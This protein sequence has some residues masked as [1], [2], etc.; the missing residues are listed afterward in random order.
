MASPAPGDRVGSGL[1][2]PVLMRIPTSTSN[3]MA[4]TVSRRRFL[5]HS[6][7]TV[8]GAA[9]LSE[10][11]WVLTAHAVPDDPIR[12]GLIG[13]G[14]R[15]TGAAADALGAATKVI[16]PQAGYHTEELAADAGLASKNVK[17]IALADVFPD[18]LHACRVQ[19]GRLKVIS[20]SELV[21]SCVD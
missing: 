11:P 8:A 5:R 17:V 3:S 1:E 16:Y 6:S 7:L 14:G 10:L 20:P 21:L 9:A 2:G 13:C 15:G 4:A 19:L 18:R 12:I